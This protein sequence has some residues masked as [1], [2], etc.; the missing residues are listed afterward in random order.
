MAQLAPSRR[1]MPTG[2]TFVQIRSRRGHV[3][4]NGQF[5]G[6]GLNDAQ[7][8]PRGMRPAQPLTQQ[9]RAPRW[10]ALLPCVTAAPSA[11]DSGLCV[12]ALEDEA[13]A[14]G[15]L[16]WMADAGA[17]LEKRLGESAP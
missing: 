4:A 1:A 3:A 17:A 7:E 2:P 14:D 13:Q 6:V 12:F 15:G 9:T 8:Y 11:A 16:R 5:K 10:P